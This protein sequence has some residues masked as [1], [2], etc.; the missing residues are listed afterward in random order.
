M[1]EMKLPRAGSK[2]VD[3]LWIFV[4]N[5]LVILSEN[6]QKA[7]FWVWLAATFHS[8]S[9]IF[10]LLSLNRKMRKRTILQ[11]K[12]RENAM[13]ERMSWSQIIC[14]RHS[15]RDWSRK[16]NEQGGKRKEIKEREII[17]YKKK[18]RCFDHSFFL[19]DSLAPLLPNL[20]RVA[21]LLSGPVG[22]EPLSLVLTLDGIWT[23]T[24]W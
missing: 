4:I 6:E 24:L 14:L 1:K 20:S 23:S 9:W 21:S 12:R 8:K 5:D 2:K 3:W 11:E 7:R 17:I 13:K 15:F 22:V 16:V 10:S 18:K 19:S